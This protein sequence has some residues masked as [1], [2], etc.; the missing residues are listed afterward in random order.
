M[1]EHRSERDDENSGDDD[2]TLKSHSTIQTPSKEHPFLLIV[3]DGWGESAD[4][5]DNAVSLA[6][7]PTMDDLKQ[8]IRAALSQM[9][10]I[11]V[12]ICGTIYLI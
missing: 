6:H 2:F 1:S 3:L 4:A 7:T 11:A 9:L 10:R 12:Q 5:E 8:V